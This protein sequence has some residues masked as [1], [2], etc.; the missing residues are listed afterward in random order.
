[1]N[2]AELDQLWQSVPRKI[3][4]AEIM[5]GP[6]PSAHGGLGQASRVIATLD[7]GSRVELLLF[8]PR[9]RSFAPAEFVGLSVAEARKLK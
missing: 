1:M 5:D 8:A 2:A 6:G 7:D 3:R 9:E 4:S